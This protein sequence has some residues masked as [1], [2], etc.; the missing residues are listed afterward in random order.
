[1][2]I[3]LIKIIK[4]LFKTKLQ[5]KNL[6]RNQINF[7]PSLLSL[8]KDIGL[9][10][11][12]IKV[13]SNFPE[14]FCF[15]LWQPK[16]CLTS[17]IEKQLTREE[18]RTVLLHEKSHLINRDPLKIFII[19]S[20]IR[21][22]FFLPALKLLL[23]NFQ[24]L[25]EIEADSLATNNFQNKEI[26]SRALVKLLTLQ[27]RKNYPALPSIIRFS[28]IINLRVDKLLNSDQRINIKIIPYQLLI[29]LL[30]LFFAL[31]GITK[32][33]SFDGINNYK[34]QGC[35]M[36]EQTIMICSER[37]ESKFLKS[38]Y[39]PH[40]LTPNNKEIDLISCK[41]NNFCG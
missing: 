27:K 33:I 13:E 14:I 20:L 12:V 29:S 10:N 8:I 32:I 30:F 15:G 41:F 28:N 35:R 40:P 31:E 24:A 18:L 23:R 34:H 19:G 5:I 16:I 17:Q 22:L 6:T 39:F 37:E 7:S 36:K 2:L 3:G 21:M 26:L 9:E 1:L 25:S 4:F 11:K 38:N